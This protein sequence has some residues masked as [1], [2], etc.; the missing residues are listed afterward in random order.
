MFKTKCK[1]LVVLFIALV[2]LN[3]VKTLAMFNGSDSSDDAQTQTQDKKHAVSEK[4]ASSTA[5]DSPPPP[6]E[7]SDEPS[8]SAEGSSDMVPPPPETL[9]RTVVNIDHLL[10]LVTQRTGGPAS[11]EFKAIDLLLQHGYRD[12]IQFLICFWNM[13]NVRQS[14]DNSKQNALDFSFCLL[15]YIEDKHIETDK[16][17][18]LPQI[19]DIK[20]RLYHEINRLRSIFNS[21]D[22]LDY[23]KKFFLNNVGMDT[24]LSHFVIATEYCTQS[25]QAMKFEKKILNLGPRKARVLTCKYYAEDNLEKECFFTKFEKKQGGSQSGG[26]LKKS[27]SVINKDG[28]KEEECIERCFVKTH[29]NGSRLTDFTDS[30]YLSFSVTTP[31][32]VNINELFVYKVLEKLGIGPEVKFVINP[33]S[34][35]NV[36]IVTKDV[37]IAGPTFTSFD[38]KRDK[39]RLLGANTIIAFTQFDLINRLLL[40][41]DLNE[42]NYLFQ[43]RE[44]IPVVRIVDFIA[45]S[46][47]PRYDMEDQRFLFEFTNANGKI[48]KPAS[49][50]AEILKN[51]KC[52]EESKEEDDE[53]TIQRKQSERNASIKQLGRDALILLPS[54]GEFSEILEACKSEVLSFLLFE[55]ISGNSNATTLGVMDFN[56]SVYD[57]NEYMRGINAN[58]NMMHRVFA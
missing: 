29:Q 21:N 45:P 39:T 48:Y 34:L 9:L 46:D 3:P 26:I 40:L 42:G 49:F 8:P 18:I 51:S 14:W 15:A 57:L 23:I 53:A 11:E 17:F 44:P 4:S 36:F 20:A 19:I 30:V 41:R 24:Y 43:I 31:K 55:N 6:P 27:I 56:E 25:I 22:G 5:E 35:N 16:C 10:E 28:K 12:D 1:L 54:I 33:F 47:F 7:K 2:F 13:Y 37:S 50:A 38:L 58:I 32:S 52:G